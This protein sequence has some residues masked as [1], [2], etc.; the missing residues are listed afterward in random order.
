MWQITLLSFL[1]SEPWARSRHASIYCVETVNSRLSLSCSNMSQYPY[2]R[3]YT[4]QTSL[5]FP[6]V[7]KN[8]TGKVIYIDSEQ[9]SWPPST[10]Q[11]SSKTS[12]RIHDRLCLL[13]LP[14]H[15]HSGLRSR[16][17]WRPWIMSLR[18]QH[19][20]MK[21][22][23][24]FPC[25]SGSHLCSMEKST[26]CCFCLSSGYIITSSFNSQLSFFYNNHTSRS[27]SPGISLHS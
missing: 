7:I 5:I 11:P 24:F 15:F 10:S 16:I 9:F 20:W 8:R 1:F 6:S 18:W 25:N 27:L 17:Y 12:R 26:T 2:S 21:W 13:K 23:I 19:R 22:A 14:R 3:R 4:K